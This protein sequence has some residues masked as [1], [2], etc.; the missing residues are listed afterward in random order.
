MQ[1]SLLHRESLHLKS[2][3]W[4]SISTSMDG[5]PFNKKSP[6]YDLYLYH[7]TKQRCGLNG[8]VKV[9]LGAYFTDPDT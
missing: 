5:V 4:F 9:H 8:L 7:G 1:N 2:V 6:F 3:C